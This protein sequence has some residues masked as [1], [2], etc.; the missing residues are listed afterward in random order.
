[1]TKISLI[2]FTFLIL[3]SMSSS[4]G[5]TTYDLVVEGMKCHQTSSGDMECNYHVG[6]SL[7]F[8]IV[9]PGK[10]DGSIYF[11]SSSF[12]G[13]YFAVY[14]LLHKCVIVRPGEKNSNFLDL[15]FVSSQNGKVY[16]TWQECSEG[17]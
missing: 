1:M 14:G 8:G 7:H 17:N 16:R 13:D 9:A 5:K 4:Q 12:E 15:A 11:Y 6:K 2:I 3:P 10:P